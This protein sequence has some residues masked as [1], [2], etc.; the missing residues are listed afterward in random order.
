MRRLAFLF[1]LVLAV[2]VAVPA[3]AQ[4]AELVNLAERVSK[5]L[6]KVGAKSAMVFVFSGPKGQGTELGVQLADEFA[7]ALAKTNKPITVV[8][9]AALGPLMQHHR[10]APK[11]ASQIGVSCWL[12]EQAGAKALVGGF[13][14]LDGETVT[15]TVRGFETKQVKQITKQRQALPLTEKWKELLNTALAPPAETVSQES[16]S[17]KGPSDSGDVPKA[18]QG[19][20]GFAQCADCPH[21]VYTEEAR[22]AKLECTVVLRAVINKEG[23]AEQLQVERPCPLGLTGEAIQ[24]VAKWKF[25]PA[26]GPD[27]QAMVVWTTIEVHFRITNG[28]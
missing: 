25:K 15:L 7:A 16:E 6:R 28:P 27:G 23:H 19:G 22:R 20:A 4:Q 9:R 10:I 3:S 5:D 12:S 24:A 1:V 21:P 18:G 14:E 26:K 11:F 2:L 8:D 17:A 13:F